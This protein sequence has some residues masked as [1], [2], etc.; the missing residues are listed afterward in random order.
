MATVISPGPLPQDALRYPQKWNS[1]WEALLRRELA[2]PNGPRYLFHLKMSEITSTGLQGSLDGYPGLVS[3]TCAI[4]RNI[5]QE[6]LDYFTESD[7]ETRW[8][9]A[10]ADVRGKHILDSMVA[11]CSKA[12]NLNEARSYCPELSLKRLRSNGKAFLD[13]LR[14]VMLEDASF[15]PTEPKFVSHPG[16]DA[17]AAEQEKLNDSELKKISFAE[18]LILRT[19]LISHVVQFTLRSFFGLSPPAF[20]VQKEQKSDQ[21]L[22]TPRVPPAVAALLGRAETANLKAQLKDDTAAVKAR[23]RCTKTEAADGS[24]KFSRCKTCFEKMQRQV[25]YCSVF[26]SVLLI[27]L[28]SDIF[29]E[30]A[31]GRIGSF[32]TRLYAAKPS[33]SRLS[34]PTENPVSASTAE[35]RIGPP[36]DGYNR[37]LALI[38]RVTT[39]NRN[40]M[41]DYQLYD[42][43]DELMDIDFG[44]GTY[45]QLAFRA[46]RE[47]AMTTGDPHCVALMSHYLCGLL[48]AK[49][50]PSQFRGI[51]SDMI[52][53]QFAREFGLADLRERVLI[54]QQIEDQDPLHRPPLL[55]LDWWATLSND[56]TLEE[57]PVTPD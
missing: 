19:K 1:D 28:L 26:V 13:L 17:W 24:V 54:V 56:A 35:T 16:W 53:A 37:P 46:C 34:Q 50:G 2:F 49:G 25:L 32:A 18:I 3:A 39:L 51:T 4:Q 11:L 6:A 10:R 44:A 47:R 45:P 9:A 40:P 57:I 41:A 7:L 33:I 52:V 38:A 12:R 48:M 14:S 22:K 30:H 8:M 5:T 31:K 20:F 27:L 21:K 43:N 29:L 42:A 23:Y 55:T 15:I 36:T